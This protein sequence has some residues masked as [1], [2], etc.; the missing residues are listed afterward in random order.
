M[1]LNIPFLVLYI[2]NIICASVL[3]CLG[4]CRYFVVKP[5]YEWYNTYFS[6]EPSTLSTMM[7]VCGFVTLNIGIFMDLPHVKN[8]GIFASSIGCAIMISTILFHTTQCGIAKAKAYHKEILKK[9][10]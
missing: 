9:R 1:E 5:M 4:L 2:M 10:A 7:L 8:A 3:I 6:S